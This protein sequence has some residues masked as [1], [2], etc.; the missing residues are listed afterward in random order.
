MRLSAV[1]FFVV[2]LGLVTSGCSVR[3]ALHGRHGPDLLALG[4]GAQRKAVEGELGNPKSSI[5]NARG[6]ST[7][8]Y[9]YLPEAEPSVFRA[10][11][12]GVFDILSLG[13]WELVAK[14]SAKYLQVEYDDKDTVV[15]MRKPFIKTGEQD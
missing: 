4:A 3:D 9:E 2:L 11:A 7:D 13:A 14:P 8:M 5:P 12:Y 1:Y 6:G 10:F 15:S